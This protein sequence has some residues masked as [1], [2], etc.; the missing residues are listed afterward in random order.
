MPIILSYTN[1]DRIDIQYIK[2]ANCQSVQ[3][4]NIGNNVPEECTLASYVKTTD[5][6]SLDWP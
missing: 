5:L 6:S 4:E 1:L 2:F 3:L